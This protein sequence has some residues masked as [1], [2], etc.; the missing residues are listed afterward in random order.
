MIKGINESPYM[1]PL[2]RYARMDKFRMWHD[3]GFRGWRPTAT[4]MLDPVANPFFTATDYL[5]HF[6][7]CVADWLSLPW[8]E[9]VIPTVNSNYGVENCVSGA[10]WQQFLDAETTEFGVDD[11]NA[12]CSLISCGLR[13]Q[14]SASMEFLRTELIRLEARYSK[15]RVVFEIANPDVFLFHTDWLD[16][17]NLDSTGTTRCGWLSGATPVDPRD[18][19]TT[20]WGNAF[21]NGTTAWQRLIAKVRSPRYTRTW[22][23]SSCF[24]YS[25]ENGTRQQPSGNYE[26]VCECGGDTGYLDDAVDAALALNPRRLYLYS[27]TWSAYAYLAYAGSY[28]SARLNSDNDHEG[29]ANLANRVSEVNSALF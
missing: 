18:T 3:L 13:V 5:K 29:F 6:D 27:W 20:V 21:P 7:N 26:T 14:H 25:D 24:S 11:L 1:I 10:T 4:L 2:N 22:L 19:M 28:E 16:P 12:R 15:K 8:T 9:V 23:S 17:T